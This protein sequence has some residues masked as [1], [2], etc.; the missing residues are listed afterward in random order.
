MFERLQLEGIVVGN[1]VVKLAA[2]T[3]IAARNINGITLHSLLR[4][5][6]SHATNV[7]GANIGERAMSILREQFSSVRYLIIDEVSMVSSAMTPCMQIF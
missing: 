1:D 4:L 3:G 5:P 7:D 2:P 6:F